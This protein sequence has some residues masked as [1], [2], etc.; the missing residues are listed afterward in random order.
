MKP[1][2]ARKISSKTARSASAKPDQTQKAVKTTVPIG[3]DILDEII[4]YTL[5]RAQYAIYQNFAETVG[6]M[7]VSPAK[8]AAMTIIGANPGLNQSTLA[9]TMGIDRS[10]AVA[11]IDALEK[12]NYAMRVQSPNDRRTHAIV[13]TATGT[14]ALDELKRLVRKHDL[15]VTKML[16]AQERKQLKDLLR[17]IYNG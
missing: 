16:S 5:R 3:L 9:A 1:A 12:K 8:F 15:E 2:H 17:R 4:G 13:L 7:D 14:A 11:L 10:G 6:A